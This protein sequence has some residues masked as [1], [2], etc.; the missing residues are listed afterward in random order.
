MSTDTV[1]T[2]LALL[3]VLALA[4]VAVAV[5]VSLWS[6]ARGAVPRWAF[7]TRAAVAPVALPLA[8]AVATTC[9]LGSLYLSEVAK[10][11]PC[12]LCWYQRIAMYPL[13]V[14]LAVAALRRDRQVS[15]Y[16]VPIA[17]LGMGISIYH[18]L[19]E[20]FPDSVSF[21]CSADVPCSTVWVWKFHFLSIPA[22]AGIG[23]ALIITLV[24][25]GR[26]SGPRD[27][28]GT[29]RGSLDDAEIDPGDASG[30]RNAQESTA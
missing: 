16:V 27:V 4:V 1:T 23:F 19:I 5:V 2:F 7:E 24:L 14:I 15:W 11:P 6:L 17:V 25:L 22:M 29:P 12:I 20:R 10:F 13:V 21:S 28:S 30:S 18:Y 3:A 9:T 26:S 8:W